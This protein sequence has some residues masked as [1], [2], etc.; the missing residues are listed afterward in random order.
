MTDGKRRRIYTNRMQFK[1][2]ACAPV[3]ERGVVCLF[4]VLHD[5]FD[6]KIES[7]QASCGIL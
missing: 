3:N 7:I 1:S 6:L 5:I 2:L 4:G